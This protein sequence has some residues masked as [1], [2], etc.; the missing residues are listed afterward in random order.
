MSPD[1]IEAEQRLAPRAKGATGLPIVGLT[2]GTDGAWS[3]R[4]WEKSGPRRYQRHWCET[5]RV[6][7]SRLAMTYD[8]RAL[9]PPAL[10]PEL[11]RTV[12]AWGQ[13]PQAT[14]ARLR[15]GVIGA[16]SV[17]FI[18]A[19]ALA[20]MGIAHIRLMDFDAVEVHNLD[21][22]LYATR[23]DVHIAKVSVLARALRRNATASPF[24]VDEL[25]YS[26]VEEEG[27]RA[28]LDCDVL[29]S[30]VDR[31]WPRSALNFIAYAHLIPVI[32]GGVAVRVKPQGKGL[33]HADMRAHV[34]APTRRCLECLGQYN[35]GLVSTEREGFLDDPHYIAGLP[36]DHPI[37]RNENVFAFGMSAASL[38]IFQ[39]LS[40]VIAPLGMSNPGAQLYHFVNG[41]MDIEQKPDCE[42]TCF[43]SRMLAMG[44]SAGIKETAR[45][46]VA[47]QARAQRQHWRARWHKFFWSH[48]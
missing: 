26:V 36:E 2:L 35:P 5:T 7:G 42:A 19:E 4:F 34:A 21:R 23:R 33:S 6:V 43:S 15:I 3:A 9:P 29:F 20:R 47:E 1:D 11:V 37:K 24:T 28:A 27:F 38:E 41:R 32:D 31:P 30:C 17:G 14:L 44:D 40:M 10:R 13:A 46:R 45:H 39:L 25:E 16:G 12:S 8:D 18:V 48:F 22:L